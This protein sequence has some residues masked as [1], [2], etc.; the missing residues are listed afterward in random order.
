MLVG[1]EI[2]LQQNKIKNKIKT[3][4]SLLF[5]LFQQM[6]YFILLPSTTATKAYVHVEITSETPVSNIQRYRVDKRVKPNKYPRNK[7]RVVFRLFSYV[8]WYEGKTAV[9]DV[10]DSRDHY[11]CH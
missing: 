10:A 3:G 6:T 4:P 8:R 2:S 11:Q 9:W 7:K 1:Q 5:H